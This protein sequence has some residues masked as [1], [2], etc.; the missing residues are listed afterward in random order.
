MKAC[1]LPSVDRVRSLLD[2]DPRTGVFRWTS[3]RRRSDLV[4][5]KAGCVRADG[6]VEI[7][8]DG[9][10]YLANRLAWLHVTGEEPKADI[11]HINRIRSDNRFCNLRDVS[12]RVNTQNREAARQDSTTGVK[13]VSPHGDRWR[14]RI[15]DAH[16]KRLHLGVFSTKHEAE[17]VYLKARAVHH[18]EA[19]L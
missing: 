3:T 15:T 13:G 17:G 8:I 14:V 7:T 19:I 10:G 16:G 6:Y 11:D 2:Y 18:A 9:K 5:R 1:P 4:N 12:R